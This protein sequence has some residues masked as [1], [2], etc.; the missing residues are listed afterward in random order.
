MKYPIQNKGGYELRAITS[1]Q[2]YSDKSYNEDGEHIGLPFL[3]MID[4]SKPIYE[5]TGEEGLVYFWYNLEEGAGYRCSY[6]SECFVWCNEANDLIPEFG[7]KTKYA[8]RLKEQSQVTHHR[9]QLL[10][11]QLLAEKDKSAY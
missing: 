9:A 3:E 11:H 10:M 7:A 6:A 4:I 8:Q 1:E 2:W 5:Y